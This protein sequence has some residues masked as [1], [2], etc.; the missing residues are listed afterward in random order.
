MPKHRVKGVKRVHRIL[1]D[2]EGPLEEIASLPF[3]KAVIPGRIKRKKVAGIPG[4]RKITFQYPT[5]TGAKLLAKS[6]NAVQEI[7]VV[8]DDVERLKEFLSSFSQ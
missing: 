7:F 3:V 5:S 4:Y 1:K 8:T 6:S 2:F